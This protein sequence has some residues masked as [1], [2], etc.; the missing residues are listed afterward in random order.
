MNNNK[1]GHLNSVVPLKNQSSQAP[2]S[3]TSVNLDCDMDNDNLAKDQSYILNIE[4][5]ETDLPLY[6]FGINV[7]NVVHAVK[8][9]L[10]T[11]ASA[12]YISPRLVN[13]GMKVTPLRQARQVETAGGHVSNI[14]HKVEFSLIAQG[15][16][17]KSGFEMLVQF[18]IG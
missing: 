13:D 2:L 11:G 4:N 1:T 12:N 10:D 3:H 15:L 6:E 18:L 14:K 7:G 16:Q 8:A 5:K 9:L 17:Y